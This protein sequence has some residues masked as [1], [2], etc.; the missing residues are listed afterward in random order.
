VEQ[1]RRAEGLSGFVGKPDAWCGIRPDRRVG[2]WNVT[3]RVVAG[4]EG[5]V[6]I[7][8]G[9]NNLCAV[10]ADGSV[11][12]WGTNETGQLGRE[13]TEVCT[14]ESYETDDVREWPCD[15]DPAPVTGLPP[16]SEVAMAEDFAC[17]RLRDGTV[18]CWGNDRRGQL[19]DGVAEI[20]PRPVP[21]R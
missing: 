9:L 12:C 6:A 10:T 3:S 13:L 7:E 17:A 19:G 11:Q 4:L 5:V 8:K 1:V 2:C 16:A 14:E 20:S 18:W 15:Y 21:I